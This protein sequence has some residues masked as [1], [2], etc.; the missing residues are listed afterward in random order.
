MMMAVLLVVIRVELLLLRVNMQ[1]LLRLLWLHRRQ[2]ENRFHR[3]LS[4]ART[5]RRRVNI[6]HNH[7][8]IIIKLRL[9]LL[10]LVK[11][12]VV[13]YLSIRRRR[14]VLTLRIRRKWL[15]SIL[16]FLGTY[17][18]Y[19]LP[20]FHNLL[21]I[22]HHG[23]L[24]RICSFSVHRR[25]HS[26]IV[27][28]LM[29][30]WNI[31]IASFVVWSC[32]LSYW[33][34]RYC[35][36]WNCCGSDDS[37]WYLLLSIG[38]NQEWR[39][40]NTCVMRGLL[41]RLHRWWNGISICKIFA[42]VRLLQLQLLLANI[43]R[44][45]R[46]RVVLHLRMRRHHRHIHLRWHLVERRMGNPLLIGILSLLHCWHHLRLACIGFFDSDLRR[47]GHHGIRLHLRVLTTRFRWGTCSGCGWWCK[48]TWCWLFP[49]SL[50][51]N[52]YTFQVRWCHC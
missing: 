37:T 29:V 43:I 13:C 49:Y 31:R 23:R 1:L 45:I 41:L 20:F 26:C 11:E 21:R 44:L 9:L 10:L 40:H 33:Y 30:L 16:L 36:C 17:Y 15:Q 24:V 51:L 2:Y 34:L 14:G 3:T 5:S 28:R 52:L 22:T 46:R 32:L 7:I 42:I 8:I 4:P 35:S 25:H 48:H 19:L 39:W 12:K 6:P 18:Y 50:A 38:W 27:N 47:R